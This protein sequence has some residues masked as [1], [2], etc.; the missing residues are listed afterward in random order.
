MASWM[1]R[2]GAKTIGP[3][4]TKVIQDKAREGQ[5]LPTD[6]VKQAGQSDWRAAASIRG[7]F[8]AEVIQQAAVTNVQGIDNH[9]EAIPEAL[10]VNN[11]GADA[12]IPETLSANMPVPPIFQ[13]KIHTGQTKGK[14]TLIIVSSSVG[15]IV[16]MSF[17]AFVI[18]IT[19][20]TSK[21]DDIIPVDSDEKTTVVVEQNFE[22]KADD[23]LLA[24]PPGG[25]TLPEEGGTPPEMASATSPGGGTP[26][27]EGGTP[28][29]MVSATPSGGG[30]PPG[31]GGTPP[32][33]PP[34]TTSSNSGVRPSKALVG[35]WR[36]VSNK[37][38]KGYEFY[39]AR[40]S[41][42]FILYQLDNEG[43][44]SKPRSYVID[45]E[46]L[47]TGEVKLHWDTGEKPDPR[48]GAFWRVD[49][50]GRFIWDAMMWEKIVVSDADKAVT[51]IVRR[52]WYTCEYLDDQTQ[53]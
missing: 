31:E 32:G 23:P 28:P 49:E 41:D 53:P 5:L 17:I 35:H 52:N 15:G 45:K 42:G 51:P 18:V 47:K 1:V 29:E 34:N 40:S 27:G 25:G 24:T 38:S 8:S 9:G 4:S 44:R 30:T 50:Q 48:M 14:R 43:N 26:P 10:P 39:I 2:R 19:L 7:L 11:Q 6:Q 3:F 21:T 22:S 13:R 46:N 12:G 20:P 16:L 33:N 36:V 37:R